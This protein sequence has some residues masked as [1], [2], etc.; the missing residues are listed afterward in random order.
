[1]AR[2][3]QIKRG[4]LAKIPTL[5]QGE[6]GMTTNSGSERLFIGT[7]SQNIEIPFLRSIKPYSIGAL[8]E[9]LGDNRKLI[10]ASGDRTFV[11]FNFDQSVP[12]IPTASNYTYFITVRTTDGAVES[13][14]A[15][16]LDSTNKVYSYSRGRGEWEHITSH[17]YAITNTGNQTMSGSLTARSFS[18]TDG[19]MNGYYGVDGSMKRVEIRAADPNDGSM[20]ALLISPSGLKF[21]DANGYEYRIIHEGNMAQIMGVNPASIE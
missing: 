21:M 8:A 17:E 16:P 3:F 7:G 2:K 12:D 10:L 9:S 14:L 6:F 11:N 19:Y 20:G 5:A 4:L 15:L 13:A 1:M 18:V